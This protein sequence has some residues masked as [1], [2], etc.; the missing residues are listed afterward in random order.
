MLWELAHRP[1]DIDEATRAQPEAQT[2]GIAIDQLR[3]K[4][5]QMRSLSSSVASTRTIAPGHNQGNA[6]RAEPAASTTVAAAQG[7]A[8]RWGRSPPVPPRR[9][10][11]QK[12]RTLA[13]LQKPSTGML[14]RKLSPGLTSEPRRDPQPRFVGVSGAR[15]RAYCRG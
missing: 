11:H 7:S 8:H 2:S 6:T 14:R 13:V 9:P 3:S 12:T 1:P 5:R 10:S 4:Y 15:G